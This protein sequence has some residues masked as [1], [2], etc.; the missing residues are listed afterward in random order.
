MTSSGRRDLRLSRQVAILG[1]VRT[2][3]PQQ[4]TYLTLAD[5]IEA[6]IARRDHPAVARAQQLA[7]M[8]RE[9]GEA[10]VRPADPVEFVLRSAGAEIRDA[11]NA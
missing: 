3:G 7:G 2:T 8:E 4:P 11:V 6:G 9:A 5:E 10:A 1:T